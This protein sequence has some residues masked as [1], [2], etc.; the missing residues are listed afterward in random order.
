MSPVGGCFDRDARIPRRAPHT[1][2]PDERALRAALAHPP[3]LGCSFCGGCAPTPP[4]GQRTRRGLRGRNVL[5]RAFRLPRPEGERAFP[6]L[7]GLRPTPHPGRACAARGSGP[8]TRPRIFFMWGRSPHAPAGSAH[9]AW[10]SRA[11]RAFE[12]VPAPSPRGL[13]REVRAFRRLP[14]EKAPRAHRSSEGERVSPVGGAAPHAPI[15]EEHALRAAPAHPPALGCSF[16]GGCAPTPPLDQQRPRSPEDGPAPS[17][18]GRE[19][20]GGGVPRTPGCFRSEPCRV[21][22][23]IRRVRGSR[24]GAWGAAPTENTIEGG[25][26]SRALRELVRVRVGTQAVRTRAPLPAQ[27]ARGGVGG[28]APHREKQSGAGGWAE[29]RAAHAPPRPES[30]ASCEGGEPSRGRP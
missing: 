28:A 4:P 15:P 30:A 7:W 16:C 2:I 3:A 21:P 27:R 29:R 18:R 14:G 1:P 9:A 17:P 24:A 22:E 20:W 8:P 25:W 13:G 26:A 23:L 11:Q 10:P 19:G 12:G 6:P 5:S